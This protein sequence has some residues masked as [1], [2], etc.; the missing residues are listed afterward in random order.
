MPTKFDPF[1]YDNDFWI[2]EKKGK[3]KLTKGIHSNKKEV[4][5]M[6]K[7]QCNKCKRMLDEDKFSRASKSKKRQR[8]TYCKECQSVYGM[9]GNKILNKI[10]GTPYYDEVL[11]NI[12]RRPNYPKEVDQPMGKI[13]NGKKFSPSK[14]QPK[15]VGEIRDIPEKVT[16]KKEEV[17]MKKDMNY[18]LVIS[19]ARQFIFP[20]AEVMRLFEKD[21]EYVAQVNFKTK[22][23]L[24]AD[25]DVAIDKN[26]TIKEISENKMLIKIEKVK[27]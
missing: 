24:K 18:N 22:E 8:Q 12:K 9:V 21:D 6:R 5:S 7:L 10:I 13:R 23:D 3:V 26:W 19:M 1:S 11:A 25:L 14:F 17:S 16:V 4:E 2:L 27:E 20:K 15:T